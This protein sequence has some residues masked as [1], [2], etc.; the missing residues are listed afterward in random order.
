MK[1]PDFIFR[2]DRHRGDSCQGQAS[3]STRSCGEI[4]PRVIA[5][6]DL[7][8]AGISHLQRLPASITRA[9]ISPLENSASLYFG[10]RRRKNPEAKQHWGR[11]LPLRCFGPG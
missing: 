11:D 2:L 9:A 7:C 3:P 4:V 6:I 5:P 1:A 10:V 8:R